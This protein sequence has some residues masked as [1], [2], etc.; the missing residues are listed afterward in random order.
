MLYSNKKEIVMANIILLEKEEDIRL[1]A[2]IVAK[3]RNIVLKGYADYSEYKKSVKQDDIV[4]TS[5]EL[6]NKEYG[7]NYIK[8]PYTAHDLLLLIDKVKTNG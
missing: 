1:A 3:R 6:E 7:Y 5:S 4:F 8:K 2:E